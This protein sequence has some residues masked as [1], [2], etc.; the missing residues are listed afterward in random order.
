MVVDTACSGSLVAVH[1]ACGSLRSGECRMALAGGV[2]L[3]L[4]PE[5]HINFSK[6]RMMASDGK[7]KT[8][9]A[10]ADGYVRGEGCGIVVLKLLSHAL[11]DGDRILA[12]VKGSAVNQDGRSGGLTVPNGSAQRAVIRQ[13]LAN[14]GVEPRE[15]H[16]LEAHGTGTALGDP[17]EAH[18]VAA[19]LGEGRTP[20]EPLVLGSVKTNF[21]HL[22][23]A[24]GIAGMIKVILSLQH[25]CIPAH[26]HFRKLNPQIEW[27]DA[28]IRIPMQALPWPRGERRRLAGVSSFGF[29]GTNA[30]VVLEEAPEYVRQS[31]EADRPAQVL[32]LSA[33]SGKALEELTRRY[34]ARLRGSVEALA[35]FCGTANAG[36]AHFNHR[37]AYLGSSTETMLTSLAGAPTAAGESE[38]P[39]EV[40]FFFAGEEAW[41]AG[42]GRQLYETQPVFRR[43]LEECAELLEPHIGHGLADMLY[44]DAAHRFDRAEYSQPALFALEYAMAQLWISWGVRPAGVFGEGAGEYAAATVAGAWSLADGIRLIAARG[45]LSDCLEEGGAAAATLARVAASTQYQRPAVAMVSGLSGSMATPDDLANPGYWSRLPAGPARLP[46]ALETLTRAGHR[47]FLEVGPG[48]T[49]VAPAQPWLANGSSIRLSSLVRGRDDWEQLTESLARLYVAGADIDWAGF[50][51]PYRR[52]K[53]AL[54]TYPFERRRHWIEAEVRE[55]AAG[56]TGAWDAIADC[57]LRQS[58]QCGLDLRLDTYGE[59]W[60]ALAD[61]TLAYIV[62]TWRGFGVFGKPGDRHTAQ[63]LMRELALPDQYERL[64][65]RWLARTAGAALL[66]Q[67]GEEYVAARPLPPPATPQLVADAKRTFGADHIFLDYVTWCGERLQSVLTGRLSPLETLFPAGDFTRAEDLYQRAPLSQYFAAIARAAVEGAVRSHRAAPLRV[68]EIGAGT[69]A[70]AA[71]VLPAL[72][73]AGAT[74]T[75]TDVSQ[76]FL[77]HAGRKFAAYPFVDYGILDIESGGS[78]QGYRP[79]SYDVVVATNVV[80]A[81]RDVR[82]TLENVRSLLAPGGVLVLC[83]VTTYLSWFDITTA[84]I[85]GWQAFGDPWRQGHPLLSAGTWLEVLAASGFERCQAYPESGSPAEALGQHVLIAQVPADGVQADLSSEPAMPRRLTPSPAS[86]GRLS[87]APSSGQIDDLVE[88]VRCHI[89]ELLRMKSPEVISRRGRL[90]DLGLDSLMA[91]ELRDRIAKALNLQEPLPATLV[92]D[93]P[94]VEAIALYLRQDVLHIASESGDVDAPADLMT[95]RAGEIEQLE[96]EEVEALLR[97]RLETL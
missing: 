67:Q 46:A 65:G 58:R 48:T 34:A 3:I 47:I 27:G 14:A 71:A 18:A 92:F 39:P 31:P 15:I 75:F 81:T 8:F 30:H 64:I 87:G 88:L 17:I 74:Y 59:R 90:I 41:Y 52:H 55:V 84:L 77:D 22:E 51:K 25:A 54:P 63:S 26:L 37:V 72:E 53:V 23:A 35:D 42:M 29:S 43:A 89:A 4:S 56:A 82:A 24:A 57:A 7:C 93:Y 1:L 21:G 20:R 86:P 80:H 85:E 11:E 79:G 76:W 9:D 36:R 45:K 13:A 60:K 10:A 69:G 83:E 38:A 70:T 19:A 68:L 62:D 97:A 32:A 44:G 49:L 33:R 94:T 78:G 6:A 5:I 66:E 12:L 73:G 61:L 16:Y 95:A 91:I 96:D 40:V 2:N 28:Q 50:D